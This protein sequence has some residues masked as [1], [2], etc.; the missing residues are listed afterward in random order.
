MI[1]SRQ[2][3]RDLSNLCNVGDTWSSVF[4]SPENARTCLVVA[5]LPTRYGGGPSIL[6]VSASQRCQHYYSGNRHH[7]GTN[8]VNK[9]SYAVRGVF[10]G[11]VAN[12]RQ[13]NLRYFHGC[14]GIDHC[15]S[16]VDPCDFRVFSVLYMYTRYPLVRNTAS[17]REV[18]AAR[19]SGLGRGARQVA[20][21][22]RLRPRLVYRDAEE[23]GAKDYGGGTGLGVRGVRGGAR[24]PGLSCCAR[25][26]DVIG[27]FALDFVR[28]WVCLF[29]RF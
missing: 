3:D 1:C 26:R 15:C 27:L 10:Y 25:Y 13:P 9:Y 12:R 4:I 16:C 11:V 29:L 17:F 8:T 20:G 22:V 28:F 14:P 6:P 18:C 2:I 19:S 5:F 23:T 21:A 24:A 7:R